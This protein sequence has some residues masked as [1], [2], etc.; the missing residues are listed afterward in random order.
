VSENGDIH[1]IANY[2]RKTMV[3]YG[4]PIDLGIHYDGK[5]GDAPN[6]PK[7]DNFVLKHI[8]TNDLA[9]PPF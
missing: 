5:M 1:K 2:V 3:E 9:L 6:H 7:L 4:K 8:E